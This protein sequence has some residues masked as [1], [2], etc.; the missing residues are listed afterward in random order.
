LDLSNTSFDTR[1]GL[2]VVKD[3]CGVFGMLRKSGAPRIPSTV[4]IN[5]IS[6]IKY[7]GSNLG[8]GY[9]AF[10]TEGVLDRT[11]SS[12]AARAPY[13][14]Q[15]FVTGDAIAEEIQAT[16]ERSVGRVDNPTIRRIENGGENLKVW[17]G[18]LTARDS[19][20]DSL[21]E[22]VVDSVN[23]SLLQR[24]FRGRIF[25]YGRYLS[26]YK[27]VGY[28]LE[29][30]RMWGLDNPRGSDAD[31][32]IAHTRQPTNSPGSLPIWSHPFASMNTAIVHNG[33]ISSYGSNMELLNS[34][35]IKSHVGTDSEVIA[36][37]LDHLLRV[38]GLSVRDA[39]TVLTNPFE[40]YLSREVKEL[41]Y[42]Y[43]GARLDGPFAV[44]AGYADGNDT[45]LIALTDRSKFRPLLAGEDRDYFYLASEENQIR[46]QSPHAKI[47]TPEPGAFFIA[48]LNKGLIEPGTDRDLGVQN[49]ALEW[50]EPVDGTSTLRRLDAAGMEFTEINQEISGAQSRGETGVV[51]DGCRGQ[52]Y[53][54]I[55]ISTRE[56]DRLGSFKIEMTGFPGNCLANLNDGASF[57]VFGNVADDLADTMHAGSVVVHG[58]ARDVAGQALQGGHIYVRGAVGNRAAIQMRE[59]ESERP[60]LIVGETADDYLGE[61]MAGGVVMV[62]NLSDSPKPA[63]NYIGTG[64]VGGRMYIRGNVGEGQIGLLPQR[65]D[66]LHY[67]Y[68]QTLDGAI[69]KEAY[70]K[71]A[72]ADYPSVQLIS[73]YLPKEIVLRV[74][75]LFFSTKYTKPVIVERRRLDDEDMRI[76]GKQLKDFFKSFALP[77]DLLAKVL[78]SS[79][80]IVKAKEEKAEGNV[81][82]QET[83]VEE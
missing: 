32:W 66:V 50:T 43:R 10:N 20:S 39:A 12:T 17:E 25:S 54:G 74:L 28:P 8:A 46:N 76:V 7:R 82:A 44:V 1:F 79:F 22:E 35:G 5:G 60:F 41:L 63:R 80:T 38:E 4:A 77:D 37:L 19:N 18:S 24:D 33:D 56:G 73:N 3:G 57:E 81:P 26:V 14:I 29:V 62:L 65:E 40:R 48:S 45:Y 61:Y 68:S 55:G 30:A 13:R 53:L 27:E 71:I 70:Q 42:K 6:C 69:S 11:D 15:A 21:L 34:W 83:P 23:G 75:T 52:R 47:W 67:L 51:I 64:M 36:R 31:M 2:P 16:L 58:N 9:A 49:S 78:D 72:S 59:Y